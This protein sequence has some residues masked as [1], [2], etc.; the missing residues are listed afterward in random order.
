MTA[1][2]APSVEPKLKKLAKEL[3]LSLRKDAKA[4]KWPAKVA[5]ALSVVIVD[6]K[7]QISYPNKIAKQVED[8][9]YGSNAGFANPVFRK[10]T[11]SNEKLIDSTV[12]EAVS[13]YVVSS[14]ILL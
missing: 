9:E 13:D 6:Q 11:K 1:A 8:L 10:F 2:L 5:A 3:T 4:A 14:E 12:V 7:I